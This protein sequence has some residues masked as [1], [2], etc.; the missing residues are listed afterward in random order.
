VSQFDSIAVRG[1]SL[2]LAPGPEH[3]CRNARRSH[4]WAILP[5]GLLVG[6]YWALFLQSTF[7]WEYIRYP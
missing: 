4:P 2:H 7:G 5:A 6:P 1:V 3:R